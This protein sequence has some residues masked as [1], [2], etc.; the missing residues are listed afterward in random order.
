M[1]KNVLA[2]LVASLAFAG[3]TPAAEPA[4]QGGAPGPAA[5][6]AGKGSGA[7]GDRAA[8]GKYLVD[9]VGMCADCHSPRNERGEFLKDRWLWGSP[10]DFKPEHPIPGWAPVAPPIA[11]LPGWTE[12]QAVRFLTTGKDRDGRAA[13]PPMPQYRLSKGDAEAVVAHL[14]SLTPPPDGPTPAK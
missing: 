9:R 6:P 5:E 14:M 11:G 7:K 13:G 8:R 12:E 2:A 3:S 4:G 1:T 10:L